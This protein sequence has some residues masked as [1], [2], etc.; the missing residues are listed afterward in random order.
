MME[1]AGLLGLCVQLPSSEAYITRIALSPQS[2]VSLG[3]TA[4]LLCF[5]QSHTPLTSGS[6][7]GAEG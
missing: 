1:E 5:A 7:L 2:T 4:V 3:K 6:C